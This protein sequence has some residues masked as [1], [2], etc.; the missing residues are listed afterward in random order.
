MAETVEP[1]ID[2]PPPSSVVMN[3]RPVPRSPNSI[4]TLSPANRLVS[5]K[6]VNVKEMLRPAALVP[7]KTAVAS[8]SLDGGSSIEQ[9]TDAT[10]IDSP[11]ILSVPVAVLPPMIGVYAPV[12]VE[13]PPASVAPSLFSPPQL[14]VS[15]RTAA[16]PTKA[17][18]L[19]LL[20]FVSFDR[21]MGS[22]PRCSSNEK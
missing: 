9:P 18:V 14:S 2:T 8:I 16:T 4:R 12:D 19:A 22:P 13:S 10:S 20:T 15:V 3:S 5:L 17:A 1:S 21:S 7:D 6:R 11:S